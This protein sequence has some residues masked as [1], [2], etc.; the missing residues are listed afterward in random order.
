MYEQGQCIQLL[1]YFKKLNETCIF[2]HNVFL[3]VK[4]NWF[5]E[6]LNSDMVH[7]YPMKGKAEGN[8]LLYSIFKMTNCTKLP[9]HFS[10]WLIYQSS[11][12]RLKFTNIVFFHL[13]KS[14]YVES[15]QPDTPRIYLI[16][17]FTQTVLVNSIIT[18]YGSTVYN[19]V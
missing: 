15:R 18:L 10:T 8:P 6:T 12:L 13:W 3:N 2:G 7:F 19:I 5:G 9:Y 11:V 16:D 17:W 14:R 4:S 1:T